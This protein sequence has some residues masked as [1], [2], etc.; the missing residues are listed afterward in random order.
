MN[1]Q[2]IRRKRKI[3][4]PAFLSKKSRILSKHLTFQKDDIPQLRQDVEEKLDEYCAQYLTEDIDDTHPKIKII[5]LC[6]KF[7]QSSGLY[8]NAK[9]ELKEATNEY[10]K[11]M[12]AKMKNKKYWSKKQIRRNAGKIA[13]KTKKIDKIMEKIFFY[14]YEMKFYLDRLKFAEQELRHPNQEEQ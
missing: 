13:Y 4:W 6:S 14:E 2:T 10:E 11:H 1:L 9:M 12:E 3:M 5:T 8:L 7:L